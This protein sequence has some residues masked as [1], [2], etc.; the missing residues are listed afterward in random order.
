MERY[1]LS[2]EPQVGRNEESSSQ[3]K[4]AKSKLSEDSKTPSSNPI[5]NV[6]SGLGFL[7][8]PP[9]IR[10]LIYDYAIDDSEIHGGWSNAP[11]L[12]SLRKGR[13]T[14]PL[15]PA[16]ASTRQFLGLTQVCKRTRTEYR[17]IWLRHTA[18]RIKYGELPAFL[19]TFYPIVSNYQNAP[20][21][22]QI[23]WEHSKGTLDLTSLFQM[24][25]QCP[26][27]PGEFVAHVLAEGA[28]PADFG[29][30]FRDDICGEC[31]QN[32][33][34]DL[35]TWSCGTHR[36]YYEDIF[37]GWCMYYVEEYE[38]LGSL[39]CLLAHRNEQWLA[40]VREG[41]VTHVGCVLD[42]DPEKA[43]HAVSLKLSPEGPQQAFGGINDIEGTTTRY[44]EKTALQGMKVETWNDPMEFKVDVGGFCRSTV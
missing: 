37:N 41:R 18:I 43:R 26:T 7:D 8:L 25:V 22:L 24:R 5:S 2:E 13:I 19:Q 23:S 1:L 31:G 44:L 29:E 32:L 34:W 28:L 40:D 27:F 36:V 33:I 30:H 3:L 6:H 17:P 11:R 16:S 42:Q 39:N 38:Y 4:E 15:A 12:L 35:G 21:L 14:P 9:E 20:K 10:N